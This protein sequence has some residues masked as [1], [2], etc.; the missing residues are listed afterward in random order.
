[1]A[2]SNLRH[3]NNGLIGRNRTKTNEY[4][5]VEDQSE[6]EGIDHFYPHDRK[7]VLLLS[8]CEANHYSK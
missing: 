3:E 2:N 6:K 5:K 8:R 1:M 7:K 4:N